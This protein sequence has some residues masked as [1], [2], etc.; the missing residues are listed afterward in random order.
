MTWASQTKRS[1]FRLERSTR[2]F[3]VTEVGQEVY[4]HARAA[5]AE[6]EAIEDV[7]A[8]LKVE[9]QGLVRVSCPQGADR[10]LTTC[11]PGFLCATRSCGC[12]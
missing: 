3:N 6:A 2:R 4:R 5:L 12:R 7:A 8:R 11:L 9:P 1:W 10:L